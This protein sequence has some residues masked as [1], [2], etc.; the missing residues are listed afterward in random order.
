MNT[1]PEGQ[2]SQTKFIFQTT[3]IWK[4]VGL[5]IIT[6]GLYNIIWAYNL[7]KSLKTEANYN[8]NPFW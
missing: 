5:S 3:S 2:K 6:L 8:I 4:L 7:W 1:E